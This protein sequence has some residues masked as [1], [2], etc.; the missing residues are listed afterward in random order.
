VQGGFTAAVFRWGT[1]LKARSAT[2]SSGVTLANGQRPTAP[3]RRSLSHRAMRPQLNVSSPQIVSFHK[4]KCFEALSQP[5]MQ[6]L[7]IP[8]GPPHRDDGQAPHWHSLTDKDLHWQAALEYFMSL[9]LCNYEAVCV[10]YLL[11]STFASSIQAERQ[12]S[13]A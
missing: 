1:D 13:K 12:R 8:E 5:P 9:L 4:S 10:V 2:L 6:L 11:C 3:A 7:G